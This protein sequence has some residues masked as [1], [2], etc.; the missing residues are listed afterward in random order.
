MNGSGEFFS[1]EPEVHNGVPVFRGT[2]VALSALVDKLDAG[3]TVAEFLEDHPAI[4]RAQVVAFLVAEQSEG[5]IDTAEW[6]FDVSEA[7]RESSITLSVAA[8]SQLRD[9]ERLFAAWRS[10]AVTEIHQRYIEDRIARVRSRLAAGDTVR[11]TE[12]VWLK[13]VD[14]KM[15][16]H[17]GS[18]GIDTREDVLDRGIDKWKKDIDA[19]FDRMQ[20]P[21]FADAMQ[22]I[23]DMPLR[24][25]VPEHLRRAKDKGTRGER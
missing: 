6:W 8:A 12:R 7:D 4:S 17:D 23:L 2:R 16:A 3:G 10:I 5:S 19:M 15:G 11:K 14:K 22:R 21:E 18:G 13:A 1:N 20:T 25:P 24:V 9:P